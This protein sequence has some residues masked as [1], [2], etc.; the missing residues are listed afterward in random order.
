VANARYPF[1]SAQRSVTCFADVS[2]PPM[3][4]MLRD[5]KIFGERGAKRQRAKRFVLPFSQMR[6]VSCYGSTGAVCFVS[7]RP[8]ALIFSI[9]VC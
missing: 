6:V 2:R 7:S 8:L 9:A 4:L 5:G 3:Y 1:V